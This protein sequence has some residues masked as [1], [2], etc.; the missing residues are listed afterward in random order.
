MADFLPC[1]SEGHEKAR[2]FKRGVS[3]KLIP[4][5]LSIIPL[6]IKKHFPLKCEFQR[7]SE[8]SLLILLVKRGYANYHIIAKNKLIL[9]NEQ[10]NLV[11]EVIS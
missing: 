3:N 9:L 6:C 5:T 7:L 10:K 1:H 11:T 4:S 2:S 8:I